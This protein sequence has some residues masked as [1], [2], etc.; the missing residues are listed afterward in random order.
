M[1]EIKKI[2]NQNEFDSFINSDNDI[3]HVVK[4]GAEWCGPCHQLSTIISNLNNDK[5]YGALFGEI[6]VEEDSVEDII[7]EYNIKNIPVI[8]FFKNKE[9]LKRTVGSMSSDVLYNILEELK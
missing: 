1:I 9:L 6:D 8:L 3:I 2:N 5:I 7:M 4:I